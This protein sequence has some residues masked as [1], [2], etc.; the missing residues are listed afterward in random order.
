MY[1]KGKTVWITGASSGLGEAMAIE[2]AKQGARL[3]L[4]SRSRKS[5]EKVASI[6]LGFTDTV[7]VAP[8]DLEQYDKIPGIV[9]DV[10]KDFPKID[11]LVNNGGISQRSLTVETD[12]SVDKKIMDINYYGTIALTKAILPSMVKHQLGQIVTIT[13]LVGKFG[14]PLR[15]SYAASKH[16]LHGFFDSL[17]A[18]LTKTGN[19]IGITLICPGYIRTRIS[20]N[21]LVAD[22][23]KQDSLDQ[24]QANGLTPEAFAKKALKAIAKRKDEV[25][26]GKRE[27]LGIYLKRYFPGIF[28]R[29]VSKVDVT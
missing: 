18:E 23:S 13:S 22:G 21:A 6:C 17:R 12:F 14:T 2:C 15:S 20:Y 10:M 29:I 28:K 8:L 5:L 4:S 9:S 11:L 3:I 24:K 16:A 25:Y 1:Y 26:I 27:V 7:K 19:N